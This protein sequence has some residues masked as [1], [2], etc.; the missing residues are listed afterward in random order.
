MHPPIDQSE[1]KHGLYSLLERGLIPPN[2]KISFEPEPIVSKPISLAEKDNNE[3]FKHIEYMPHKQTENVYKLDSVYEMEMKNRIINQ[4][5]SSKKSTPESSEKQHFLKK[6][7]S[8]V[9]KAVNRQ[10]VQP[11]NGTI[12]L[13]PLVNK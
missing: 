1:A 6:K 4:K 7:S 2:A 12:N 9:P 10:P 11:P 3:V 8:I 5:N 13:N